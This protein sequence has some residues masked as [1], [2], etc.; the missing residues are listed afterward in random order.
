MAVF[1]EERDLVQGKLAIRM[2][3][4]NKV[5]RVVRFIFQLKAWQ[6]TCTILVPD[7]ET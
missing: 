5:S 6:P 1:S 7:R 3:K 2:F 4:N